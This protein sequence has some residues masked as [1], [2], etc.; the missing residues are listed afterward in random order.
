MLSILFVLGCQEPFSE[1]RHDLASF[2]IA[3]VSGLPASDGST[4]L[5]AALWSG[6]G[7]WHG[8]APTL[9]WTSGEQAAEGQGAA[10]VADG[11]VD[12]V[13]ASPSGEET[14]ALEWS[15]PGQPPA[16]RGFQRRA[17]DLDISAIATPV[18]D[19]LAVTPGDD[20]P[21]PAGSAVRIELDVDEGVTVHWMATG[22]QFAELDP[23]SADWFAGTAVLDDNEV[24]STTTV[25]AGVYT[26]LA[27]AL[28]GAGNNSWMWIDV[29]VDPPGQ[30]AYVAG[31]ILPAS[32]AAGVGFFEATVV[33][34]A[35]TAGIDLGEVV[36]VSDPSASPALCGGPAG[37][38]FDFAP[39]VE[40]WCARSDVIGATVVIEGELR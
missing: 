11:A 38:A 7:A 8:V 16:I 1:D 5:R 32:G 33:E 6:E 26:L 21:I 20:T 31:R 18:A 29:A 39:M 34:A 15:E 35:T 12:L 3:G 22:G 10:L 17:V 30:L 25:D 37:T 2:R 14:A 23:T 28:D 9:A 40:G 27:L 24:E 36:A 19:R 4:T 13:A